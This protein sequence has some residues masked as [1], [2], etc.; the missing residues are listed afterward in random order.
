MTGLRELC[1][2]IS[3]V[4]RL[5]NGSGN[6]ASPGILT[7]TRIILKAHGLHVPLL[8]QKTGVTNSHLRYSMQT[9]NSQA[10]G[11]GQAT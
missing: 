11:L 2:G 10:I 9:N 6:E 3:L 8:K 4:P 5:H 7:G 1:P